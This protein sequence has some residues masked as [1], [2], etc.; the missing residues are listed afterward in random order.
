MY[1]QEKISDYCYGR[2]AVQ[3]HDR[4]VVCTCHHEETIDRR[5]ALESWWSDRCRRER[6]KQASIDHSYKKKARKAA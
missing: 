4:M 3:F 1:W 5:R 2:S 6:R